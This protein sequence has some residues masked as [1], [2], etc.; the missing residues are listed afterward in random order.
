MDKEYE[1]LLLENQVCFPTYAVA[2]KILRRYQP[3]LKKINLTYTQYVTMMV[4]WEKE[5]VNEK[6]LVNALYLKANTLT[7][8]LR[9][10]K[11][12]GYV[13]ISRDE[14][15][16]RNIVIRLTDEG[17]KL[18][19]AAVDVPKTLAEEHWLTDEEFRTYKALLYKLLKGEWE[20]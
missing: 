18:K 17:R 12:K 20:K 5:V 16:K 19:E 15:D 11:K 9:K 3:L 2:N 1:L 10:L 8:L 14:K 4:M 13:E 7:E 6:D